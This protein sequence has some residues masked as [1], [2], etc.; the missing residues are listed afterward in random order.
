MV[1]NVAIAFTVFLITIST[2]TNVFAG[3]VSSYKHRDAKL[4][5]AK[6][7][8]KS[9][10]F[11]KRLKAVRVFKKNKTYDGLRIL[12]T[13]WT[14]EKNKN[15]IES[16]ENAIIEFEEFQRSN[17]FIDWI[18]EQIK[19]SEADISLLRKAKRLLAKS[20]APNAKNLISKIEL[21]EKAREIRKNT[22]VD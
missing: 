14:M 6:E 3:D 22:E 5:A 1:K 4:C 10:E 12:I 19:I 8:L 18:A 11:E 21:Q 2:I 17:S 20:K 15:V 9:P 16:L 7:Q 13:A